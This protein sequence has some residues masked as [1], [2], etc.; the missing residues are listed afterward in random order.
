[1]RRCK[2]LK[3][4]NFTLIE[5]LI[6]IAIIVILAG[7]LLPALQS[8]RRKAQRLT[9][10]GNL[11]QVG[12][13]VLSYGM[14]N[15]DFVLPV[16]GA[17]RNMGG[18]SWMYWD[19]YA[20]YHMGI[21][22]DNPDVSK[23]YTDNIPK[24]YRYGI[25]KCPA[26][27]KPVTDFGYISYGMLLYYIG[28]RASTLVDRG[29][30]GL[31][32]T[33]IKQPSSVAYLMDSVYSGRGANAFSSSDTSSHDEMGLYVVYNNGMNVSRR[34]HYGQTNT[35]LVDGHV[36]AFSEGYL[37]LVESGGYRD[38]FLLGWNGMM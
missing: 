30:P 23:A 35:F 5:L 38:T 27:R 8:A 22:I 37:R 24:K 4:K 34:R 36:E 17:Y 26:V 2:E 7:L 32:F 19:Y 21:N 25:M 11:K 28:G 3:I 1:M 16:C 18:T 13:G 33:R 10:A 29:F 31:T 15:K 6:V 14:D 9:C 12:M 20:R